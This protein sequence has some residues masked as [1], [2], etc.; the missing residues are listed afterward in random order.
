M[1]EL[2]DNTDE[3]RYSSEAEEVCTY[4]CGRLNTGIPEDSEEFA[5][6]VYKLGYLDGQEVTKESVGDWYHPKPW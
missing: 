2:L 6:K 1:M 4:I 5:M 3:P